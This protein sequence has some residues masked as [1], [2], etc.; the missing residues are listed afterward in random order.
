MRWGGLKPR[1]SRVAVGVR[2]R[3]VKRGPLPLYWE[4]RAYWPG[5]ESAT[6]G[7]GTERGGWSAGSRHERSVQLRWGGRESGRLATPSRCIH[8]PLHNCIYYNML[9]ILQQN[10]VRLQENYF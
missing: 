2:R 7:R 1:E 9:Y 3:T 5:R 4:W 8:I 10:S 6:D